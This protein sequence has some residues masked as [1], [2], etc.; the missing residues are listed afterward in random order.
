MRLKTYA[1]ASVS[2]SVLH[3][4]LVVI[5][6]EMFGFNGGELWGIPAKAR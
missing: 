4:L 5:G 3:R 2:H 6:R 1:L